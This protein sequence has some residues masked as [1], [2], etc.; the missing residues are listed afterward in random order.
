MKARSY[1]LSSYVYKQREVDGE[2]DSFT[3][4]VVI[5]YSHP[6]TT[7]INLK[8]IVYMSSTEGAALIVVTVL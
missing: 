2:F 6:N 7:S 1:R 8:C 3:N 5:V 4:V